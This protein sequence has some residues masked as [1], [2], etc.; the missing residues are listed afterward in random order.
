MMSRRLS[1]S[2]FLIAV[3]MVSSMINVARAEEAECLR[4]KPRMITLEELAS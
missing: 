2:S 4:D 1:L 3:L